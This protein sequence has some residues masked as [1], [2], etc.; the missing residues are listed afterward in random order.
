[1]KKTLI[2]LVVLM[3]V[4]PVLA[5]AHSVA[6]TWVAGT[7]GTT[8]GFNVKRAT[9]SG[10]PYTTIGSTTVAVPTYSD[11]VGLVEGTTYFYVVTATGLGGESSPSNE[12]KAVIPFLLPAAP[13]NLSAVPK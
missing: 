9:V 2:L 5:Q 7:G 12:V 10:G 11:T 8:T 1:M 6:L 3:V 4:M 13:S